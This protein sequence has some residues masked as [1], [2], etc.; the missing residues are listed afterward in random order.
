MWSLNSSGSDYASVFLSFDIRFGILYK[1][2]SNSGLFRIPV[3]IFFGL[4]ALG[5]A[6]VPVGERGLDEWIVNFYRSIN[7][8]LRGSG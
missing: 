6:F 7:S 2:K 8:L 4:L 5:L 1:F 3:A